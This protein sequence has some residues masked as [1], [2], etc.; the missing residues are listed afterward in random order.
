L[1]RTATDTI[2]GFNYQFNRTILEILNAEP[3]TKIVLEG[4][5]EDID[6]FKKDETVAIQCKYYES[7]KNLNTVV[8]T[9]PILDMIV[10]FIKD[11][12]ISYKLYIH[13]EN[14]SGEENVPFNIRVLNNIL[15]TKNQSYIK[16]YFPIIFET[17][18][19]IKNLCS[20]RKLT[21]IEENSI[22][23]YYNEKFID[24][25]IIY[26][27]DRAK[28]IKNVE[29]ISAPS[30]EEL[31][32]KIIE[33]ISSNGYT[34][35]EVYELFYPNMFQKVACLS[36]ERNVEKR[37]IICGNFKSN[38]FAI[39][40]LLTSKWLKKVFNIEQ[41]K[42]SL[43]RN[44]KLR[45]QGNSNIRLIIL[46][47]D[48]YR[49]EDITSFVNDYVKKY[50]RKPKLN[51]APLF[52]IRSRDEENCSLIQQSLYEQY[53]L[54]FEDGDVGK[55]FN[56]NKLMNAEKVDLKICYMQNELINYMIE[57]KPDD[58]FIIGSLDI[59]IYEK[60]GIECCKIEG[61][62]IN[63]VKEI[64]FLGGKYEGNR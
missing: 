24:G 26:K 57:H 20:R 3:D 11:D 59:D 34:R 16:K 27:F 38:I 32:D 14:S 6:V 42:K 60:N 9:K 43:K 12:A 17:E 39:K 35:E 54:N 56:I 52:I 45:L 40:S 53:N 55:K 28:F 29:I 37:T 61:L 7:Y 36:S 41:Y 21:S 25:T 2:K 46:D 19:K 62:N 49:I 51:K 30:N 5:I 48:E 33:T 23:E 1:D 15:K 44:L 64:F 63:E 18:E 50:N 31:V 10:S 47:A 58:I 22:Y 13:C 8:L 4:Y